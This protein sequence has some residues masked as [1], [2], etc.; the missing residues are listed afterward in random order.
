MHKIA[1]STFLLV[2]VL[3]ALN[4]RAQHLKPGFDKSEF[5]ELLKIGARTTA[6][7]SYY[8]S[9]AAPE[10]YKMIYQSAPIGLDNLWQLWV[11]KDSVAVI[12][13]RGTT[14]TAISF[15]QNFYAAMVSAKGQLNLEKN[16]KFDYNLSDDP[17]A[18]VHIGFL[19][20]AAYLSRDI[21]PKID[22]IYKN[23]G[24]KEF[25]IAGHSQGGAITYLLTS[26]LE[27]MK[28]SGRLPAEIRFKTCASAAPKP[29]N[30]FYAYDFENLT[31]GGWAYNA[32]NTADWVPEVPFSIQTLNDFNEVNPF[33]NAKALIKKQKF[34]A[35]LALRHVY[36]RLSKP[37][38]RAQKNYEKFLGKMISKYI[39]KSLPDFVPP[40]YF[41]SNNYVRTGMTI[42]LKADSGYY[43]KFPQ[44]PNKIW[45]NHTQLPYLFLA[46]KLNEP[47]L[48]G[49]QMADSK[50]TGSW[51]LT[52]ISGRRIAFEGLYPD[53]KPW[54]TIDADSSKIN[55]NTS[56]NI[57]S[58]KF[59]STG[60]KI[61]FA[62]PLAMTMMACPGEGESAF[63]ETLNKITSYAISDDGL[64]SLLMNGV[65]M[66]RF[67]KK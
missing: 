60:N 32:V 48:K 39:K 12:S 31:R 49:H 52:Y 30:L 20:G 26:Y 6:D 7:S 19:I 40:S 18:A 64:L 13:V 10:N 56:C 51:E 53:R 36:N 50:L 23:G 59:K 29:G 16:F 8:N 65:E 22:S 24:V 5:I 54:I 57:F 27:S 17:N 34:P 62:G 25:I 14:T 28:K 15:L 47:T 41:S 2:T 33:N 42:V 45:M 46:E 21:L 3:L 61:N 43:K 38:K 44:N 9:F 67:K 66:M 63:V 1:K 37:G 35:N 4:A 58:G 55:G 11:D